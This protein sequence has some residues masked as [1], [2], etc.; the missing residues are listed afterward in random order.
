MGHMIYG[1]VDFRTRSP[2][3]LHASQHYIR[4]IIVQRPQESIRGRT[5][6]NAPT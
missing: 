1:D 4:W 5:S 2:D 6:A 3:G